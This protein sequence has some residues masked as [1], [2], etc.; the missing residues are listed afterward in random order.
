MAESPVNTGNAGGIIIRVG[1]SS[2]SSGICV[3]PA[4]LAFSLFRFFAFWLGGIA[5]CGAG[6]PKAPQTHRGLLRPWSTNL[7]ARQ[8][9][10]PKLLLTS[11]GLTGPHRRGRSPLLTPDQGALAGALFEAFV[12]MEIV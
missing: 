1:G 3:S 6:L 7:G 8:V 12:V 2:P 9:K 11:T 4:K 10:T 5:P